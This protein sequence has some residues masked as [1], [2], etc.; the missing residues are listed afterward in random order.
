MATSDGRT[1]RY[2][3]YLN[4][5]GTAWVRH[6]PFRDHSE[7]GQVLSEGQYAHG[8][9][10][11]LWRDFHPSGQIA[12]EGIYVDGGESGWWRFWN[13][14]GQEERKTFFVEGVEVP[15][16]STPDRTAQ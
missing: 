4:A 8:K 15:A 5:E 3:R 13:E 12:A 7:N 9:E 14:S 11:G 10:V 2:F 6:G 16:T 1:V